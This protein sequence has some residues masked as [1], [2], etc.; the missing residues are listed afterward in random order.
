MILRSVLLNHNPSFDGKAAINVCYGEA[1]DKVIK[2]VTDKSLKA[3]LK[4]KQDGGDVNGFVND[5]AWFFAMIK[6]CEQFPAETMPFARRITEQ[7]VCKIRQGLS[8]ADFFE[9]AQMEH[10]LEQTVNDLFGL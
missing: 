1:A 7:H 9:E 2:Y 5:S 6:S 4:A 8:Y 3:A 10:S